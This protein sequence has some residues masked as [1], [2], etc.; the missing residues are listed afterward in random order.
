M[1]NV[2]VSA[3]HVHYPQPAD[4][5]SSNS[6]P[7]SRIRTTCSQKGLA[8]STGSSRFT[9]ASCRR[10]SCRSPNSSYIGIT[11]NSG[12]LYI[13]LLHCIDSSYTE[14]EILFVER[15]V[16]KTIDWNLPF[17]NPMRFLHRISKAD[18]YDV[19]ARTISGYLLKVG[20]LEWRLSAIPPSL[21]ATASI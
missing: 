15:Y 5:S 2:E 6:S 19:K 3:S 14:S 1:K 10:G 9:R 16:L 11:G 13:P 18:D 21:M 7:P 4:P 8:W 17:P 12:P 20:T